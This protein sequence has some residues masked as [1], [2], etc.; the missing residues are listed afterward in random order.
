MDYR[1]KYLKYKNK[2]LSLK[3]KYNSINNSDFLNNYTK[4]P[5]SGQR[6]CGIYLS[7][8]RQRIMKCDGSYNETLQKN[9]EKINVKYPN[10]KIFPKISKPTCFLLDCS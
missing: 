7:D 2:Y 3:N 6:N 5:N 1:T 4:I 8:D 9:L 10:Y